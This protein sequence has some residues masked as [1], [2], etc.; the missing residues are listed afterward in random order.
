MGVVLKNPKGA[1]LEYAKHS[2]SIY[3]KCPN[4]C[5]YCYLNRGVGSKTLGTGNPVLRSCFKN[6]E[7]AIETF[8]KEVLKERETL[9]KDGG[10]FFCFTTDPCLPQTI[11]VTKECAI[12]AMNE[13]VPV[14][15]LT[16]MVDWAYKYEYI[17][18]ILKLGKKTGLLCVGFTLTGRD[19]MEP[20]AD[21][22][23][24]RIYAM[25]DI[26]DMGI[27]TFASIEPIIQFNKSLA[28]IRE[29]LGYCDLYKI[30]LM[31]K[32]GKGYYEVADCIQFIENVNKL[33][34]NDENCAKVYWKESIRK[35][36]DNYLSLGLQPICVGSDYNI[37]ESD[38]L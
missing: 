17:E 12:F 33:I 8:K 36:T 21:N 28:M 13:G 16:K 29:T 7:Q 25:Q 23:Q 26:H 38:Y 11:D 30:G 2:V 24:D 6:E 1:A 5:R 22:N 10:V 27:K 32:C 31:S 4:A 20:F 14:T 3:R 19:D 9:I 15:I 34:W 37:F 18:S 35:F